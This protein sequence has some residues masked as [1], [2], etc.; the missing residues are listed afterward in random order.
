[1]ETHLCVHH[2]HDHEHDHDQDLEHDD[3]DLGKTR[4]D[5]L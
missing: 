2:D 1:M 5:T 3:D 4:N